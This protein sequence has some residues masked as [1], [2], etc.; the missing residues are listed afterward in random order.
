MVDFGS[1]SFAGIFGF[2]TLN[3]SRCVTMSLGCVLEYHGEKSAYRSTWDGEMLHLSFGSPDED[4]GLISSHRADDA[5]P[6]VIWGEKAIEGP[7]PTNSWYLV[8]CGVE[9]LLKSKRMHSLFPRSCNV[10]VPLY[11]SSLFHVSL[12]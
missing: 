2:L 11:P 7:L 6:S 4:L 8:C 3:G 1:G 5:S 12:E 10:S 9:E